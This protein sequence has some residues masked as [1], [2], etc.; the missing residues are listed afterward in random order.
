MVLLNPGKQKIETFVADAQTERSH[1]PLSNFTLNNL[2]LEGLLTAKEHFPAELAP[3]DVDMSGFVRATRSE[4]ALRQEQGIDVSRELAEL[5]AFAASD[6]AL[7]TQESAER[8]GMLEH[9][10]RAPQRILSRLKR[11]D[12]T[13]SGAFHLAGDAAGFEDALG[14]SVVLARLMDESTNRREVPAH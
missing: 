8:P 4:L 7:A 11:R 1:T 2:I 14:A 3:Y 13:V 5:D 6:P 12:T 9:V 10:R